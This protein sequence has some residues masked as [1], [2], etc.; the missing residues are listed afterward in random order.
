MPTGVQRAPWRPPRRD[1]PLA[2]S[3]HRAA[4]VWGQP[5]PKF[6][7]YFGPGASSFAAARWRRRWRTGQH[8]G[9]AIPFARRRRHS[10]LATP[11]SPPAPR[12]P[13]LRFLLAL[14]ALPFAVALGWLGCDGM[15]HAT[16]PASCQQEQEADRPQHRQNDRA[17]D[18]RR[19]PSPTS[20]IS[21]RSKGS[22]PLKSPAGW[23]SVGPAS[24]GFLAR[25]PP[26][27]RWLLDCRRA[28][29]HRLDVQRKRVCRPP[30]RKAD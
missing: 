25:K 8:I 29:D 6:A 12:F 19:V 20:A 7:D 18:I 16:R 5:L 27:I 10:R 4:F 23:G 11:A 15:R 3:A 1:D 24:I 17:G 22:A 21:S 30:R 2:A 13:I 28:C 14:S 26:A 9:Y